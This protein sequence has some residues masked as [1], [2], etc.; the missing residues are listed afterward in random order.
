MNNK[1]NIIASALMLS[2]TSAVAGN[3]TIS[4]TFQSG[5]PASAAEVNQN[6]TDVKVAVDDNDSRI[7]ANET[8]TSNNAN[9]ISSNTTSIGAI[10]QGLSVY[11]N[12]TRIGA[13]M[14]I[15][16]S[17][18]IISVLFDSGNM[19]SI[20]LS[21]TVANTLY[22]S[23]SDC[24]GQAYIGNVSSTIPSV[25]PTISF[26]HGYAVTTSNTNGLEKV[27]VS[28]GTS[29]ETANNGSFLMSDTCYISDAKSPYIVGKPVVANDPVS[30]GIPNS[31]T[32]PITISY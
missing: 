30:T 13:L 4:N 8:A 23:T 5:T 14:S 28:P 7:S 25:V 3:V 18:G 11:D 2:M 15:D 21:G 12:G 29:I 17:F 31:Y 27:F 32:G 6:F 22:Y 20:L 19:E 24:T 26:D 1:N 10:H 16:S 9:A